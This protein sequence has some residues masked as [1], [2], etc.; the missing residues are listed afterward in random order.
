MRAA[1]QGDPDAQCNLGM[2][3]HNGRGVERND[4]AAFAWYGKAAMQGH[5][6]AQFQL[7]ELWANGAGCVV[8][9]PSPPPP[10]LTSRAFTLLGSLAM[11]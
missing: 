1:E 9:M 7:A 8:C 11:L 3:F 5:R 2:C 4:K 6:D 10:R